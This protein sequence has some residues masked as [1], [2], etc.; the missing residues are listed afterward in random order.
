MTITGPSIV[1]PMLQR[2]GVKS[3]LHH[4]LHWEGVLVDPIGV[5]FALLIFKFVQLGDQPDIMVPLK[6]LGL[7]LVTGAFFGG[8]GGLLLAYALRKKL[9][10]QHNLNIFVLASA[11]GIFGISDLIIYES[12]LL[13]VTIAGF[14]IGYQGI[15]VV[16][17]LRAYKAELIELLIGML[18]VLLAAKLELSRFKELGWSGLIAVLAVMLVVRPLTVFVSTI[19]SP[20]RRAL[21]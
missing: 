4:L 10:P 20:R 1:G 11:I 12:G 13:A 21:D 5:F 19:G 6:D 14:T 17:N 18:F 7:R 8:G 3:K 16:R 15:P 2:I 9:V